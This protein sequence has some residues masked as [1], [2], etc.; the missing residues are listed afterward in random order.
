SWQHLFDTETT[1][2]AFESSTFDIIPNVEAATAYS[3]SFN[4]FPDSNT[5]AISND[6]GIAN[7]IPPRNSSP[8][9][10][11]TTNEFSDFDTSAISTG[12]N[13]PILND[14]ANEDSILVPETRVL[15]LQIY[16]QDAGPRTQRDTCQRWDLKSDVRLKYQDKL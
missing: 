2:I 11:A 7:G 8:Q 13:N 4:E 16:L 5:S 14:A 15:Q 10:I 6:N 1:V 3:I 9:S 12:Q